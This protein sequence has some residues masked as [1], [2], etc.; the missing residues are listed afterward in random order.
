[1]THKERYVFFYDHSKK[2]FIRNDKK[3]EELN[4]FCPSI[5][6]KR[7]CKIGLAETLN[8]FFELFLMTNTA[9]STQT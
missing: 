9:Y 3:K 8:V 7:M 4:P 6:G 5:K 1:M 2:A